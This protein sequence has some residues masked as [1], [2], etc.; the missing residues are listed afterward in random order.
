MALKRKTKI[1][2]LLSVIFMALF[3]VR[4]ITIKPQ[5]RATGGKRMV[6]KISVRVR[7]AN[8]GD[9]NLILSY[10]GS[11]KAKDEIF[12]F[13]KVT[14]K[15]VEYTVNEGDQVQKGEAIALIDRDETGLKYELARVESPISGIMGKTLLDKG[16]NITPVINVLQGTAVAI[17]VDMNEMTV[18][19]NIPEPDIPHIK[20]GLKATISVDAYPDENF[21]GVVTK[22]S[23]VVDVQTR[24]LPIEITIPNKEHRL[25]SGMF[26]RIDITASLYKDALFLAQD[27]VVQEMGSSYVFIVEN[28]TANKRKIETGIRDNGKIQVKEGLKEGEP[29]I[30]F[31][32]QGLKDGTPVE[33]AKE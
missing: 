28:G 4:F 21:T 22:V 17:I 15:L 9:L 32:Q 13:S 20:R 19:I 27:S 25:K 26:T 16:A 6:D 23:E 18:K 30:V 7:P 12:V 24:T 8:R 10:V 5:Q 3:A 31:G 29:V 14:G 11:L 1:I 33:I 2:L